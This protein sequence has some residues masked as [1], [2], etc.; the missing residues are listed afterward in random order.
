MAEHLGR[1]YFSF[2][3][4]KRPWVWPAII[5]VVLLA[6]AAWLV[7]VAH[8]NYDASGPNSWQSVL[9]S[10]V[11]NGAVVVVLGAAVTALLALMSELRAR[12]ERERDKRLELFRRMRDAHVRV[13]LTQQIL[14]AQRDGGTYRERM[15]DLLQVIKDLEEVREEVRVSG[16]LYRAHRTRIMHGIAEIIVYLQRGIS[17]YNEWSKTAVEGSK[18]PDKGWLKEL[19]EKRN[20]KKSELDPSKEDW[21]PQGNMPRAYDRGLEKS[22]FV[23][24]GY[25]YGS[26]GH[27]DEAGTNSPDP[28]SAEGCP[29]GE[30]GE[31]LNRD[32][33]NS[34]G[35]EA[36]ATK[37]PESGTSP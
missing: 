34:P 32:A 22:K 14:R 7:D 13:A 8:D 20:S 21:E 12:T 11:L 16:K 5:V 3:L 24:R 4:A 10:G 25:V 6:A 36:F 17:Q 18:A 37:A 29:N 33:R 26:R 28:G 23:M 35:G 15:R 9:A 19:V 1:G 2:W 31:Q 27:D 30:D